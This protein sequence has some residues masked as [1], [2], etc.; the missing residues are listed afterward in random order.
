MFGNKWIFN[1]N[2][3]LIFFPVEYLY[4]FICQ[5]KQRDSSSG[6]AEVRYNYGKQKLVGSN[7]F[8]AFFLQIIN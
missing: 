7:P 6:S 5:Y 8:R 2:Q 3:L 4:I 1:K